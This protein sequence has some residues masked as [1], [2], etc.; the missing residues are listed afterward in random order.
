MIPKPHLNWKSFYLFDFNFSLLSQH[1]HPHTHAELDLPTTLYRLT[2]PWAPFKP[3]SVQLELHFLPQPIIELSSWRQQMIST[4]AVLSLSLVTS[5]P[6][7]YPF[8][9]CHRSLFSHHLTARRRRRRIAQWNL[10]AIFFF[11]L[12]VVIVA[13]HFPCLLRS[14]FIRFPFCS[15]SLFS[16]FICLRLCWMSACYPCENPFIQMKFAP[17]GDKQNTI[18]TTSHWLR[19]LTVQMCACADRHRH[20]RFKRG[21]GID[22]C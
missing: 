21:G 19:V 7:L 2:R 6:F 16:V 17:N 12:F 15:F 3:P 14:T 8:P 11:P 10:S 4:Y 20:A 5:P 9:Y 18:V 22:Q 1:T 13:G